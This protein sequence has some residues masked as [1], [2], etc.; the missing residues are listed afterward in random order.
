MCYDF[1]K[2]DIQSEIKIEKINDLIELMDMEWQK[3]NY[4]EPLVE[5]CVL[6]QGVVLRY[7]LHAN[8]IVSSCTATEN[9]NT[10]WANDEPRV[11]TVTCS[12]SSK[13]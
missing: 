3:R 5:R 13:S 6:I 4:L 11:S 12:S 10:F 1:C 7:W 2:F 9:P 8:G